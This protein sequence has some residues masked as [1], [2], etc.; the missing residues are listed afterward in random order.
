M[1]MNVDPECTEFAAAV[2]RLA[3]DVETM[4]ELCLAPVPRT[5][6]Y[7]FGDASKRSFGASIL[8]GKKLEYEY[9]Q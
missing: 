5:A 8:I 7:G 1:E 3:S 4:V 2:P 9:G 6:H